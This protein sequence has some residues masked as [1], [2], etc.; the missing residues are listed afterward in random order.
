ME[1]ERVAGPGRAEYLERTVARAMVVAGCSFW[2]VMGVGLYATG[3]T[4]DSAIMTTLWPFLVTLV[5]FAIGWRN[6]RLASRILFVA[7]AAVAV[8]GVIYG[9]EGRAWALIG[10][11]VIVPMAASAVLY[12]LASR[13]RDRRE[14]RARAG[15][16]KAGGAD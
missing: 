13:A 11:A 3:A 12:E 8:W 5:A 9:W 4:A 15:A 1:A 2:I 7:A 6:E 16:E 10:G 14:E